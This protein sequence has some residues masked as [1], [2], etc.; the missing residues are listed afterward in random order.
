VVAGG[1][2]ALEVLGAVRGQSRPVDAEVVVV[3]EEP[4][5]DPGGANRVSL[6][7]GA[8]VAGAAHAG[9]R[10]GL[11]EGAD[12]LWLLDGSAVPAPEA[13]ERL[14]N[15]LDDL[16]GLPL[17]ALLAGAVVGPDGEPHPDALPMNRLTH[18]EVVIE[19]CRR[20]LVA[21]RAVRHGS[22]LVSR[23]AIERDGLPRADYVAD[24]DDLEWTA[25]LLRDAD[26]YLVPASTALRPDLPS[27]PSSGAPT[28]RG[29]RNVIDMLR[30]PGWAG[31]EKL[32][33]G[34]NAVAGLARDLR[35]HPGSAGPAV[36]GI[37]AGLRS[38]GG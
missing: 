8:G 11:A 13:L 9:L 24:G 38:S 30:G 15:V 2:R 18:K 16:G 10:A 28:V 20:R 33:M 36:R 29:V 27:S 37:W 22:I 4:E 3:A 21:V 1:A 32:W 35:S 7:A 31:E 5:A 12:W 23:E 17:P 34:F 6:P 25:R 26:G 19:A 14:L